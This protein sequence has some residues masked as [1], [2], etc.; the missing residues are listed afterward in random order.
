M[1]VSYC[2]ASN[3]V[4]AFPRQRPKKLR[5][6]G[7]LQTGLAVDGGYSTLGREMAARAIPKLKE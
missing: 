2:S 1:K 6:H 7:G 5:G 4:I 3:P